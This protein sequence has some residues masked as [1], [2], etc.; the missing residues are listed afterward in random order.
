MR[1]GKIVCVGWN[2]RSH[3]EE[4]DAVLPERPLIFLKATSTLVADGEP[5]RIP[6]DVGAI[7][8]EVELALVI[9]KEGKNVDR[10]EAMSHISHL[11]VFNDIT[12][13]DL[14]TSAR[15]KGEPWCL[16]KSMDCFGP[17]SAYTP[18]EDAPPIEELTL[19]LRV[20]G[21]LRQSAS[22]RQ[23]VF[24]PE[25]LIPYISRFMTLEVG[26]IIITGTPEGVGPLE[27]GDV[28][29]ARIP[30]VATLRNPIV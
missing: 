6:R 2:Y 5:V 4:T 13:R 27:P 26:D 11:A 23:M 3:L 29:E 19:E 30:G 22:C 18:I 14:Q 16:S 24:G 20:N 12:A 8:H 1:P 28:V 7:H 9:G 21:E 25:E 10:S 17:I 15:D